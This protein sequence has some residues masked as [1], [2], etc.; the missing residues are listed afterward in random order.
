MKYL[1]TLPKFTD[2]I[3]RNQ[4]YEINTATCLPVN[5]ENVLI[6]LHE[7]VHLDPVIYRFM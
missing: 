4:T 2:D 3:Y 5:M 7:H 6:L 1:G